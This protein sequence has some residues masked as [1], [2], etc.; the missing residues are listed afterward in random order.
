MY[1]VE[2]NF[3]GLNHFFILLKLILIDSIFLV[4]KSNVIFYQIQMAFIWLNLIFWV[5]F[6]FKLFLFVSNEFFLL[7]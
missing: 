3:F 6:W 7:I 2:I 5:F 1:L 4:Q